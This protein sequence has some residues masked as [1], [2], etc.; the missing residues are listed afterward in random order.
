M[1]GRKDR[2]FLEK[3]FQKLTLNFTWWVNQKDKD[4]R[5]IFQGGFLGL[6]NIGI[7]N[8][9]KPLPMG[10]IPEQSDGTGWMGMYC[11]NLL[12]IALELAIEDAVYEDMAVKFLEHFIY[13]ADAIN[14]I[15]GRVDGL[16]DEESGFYRGFLRMPDGTR[17]KL[18]YDSIAGII[19]L[20]AVAVN[21]PVKKGAFPV[22]RKSFQWLV[23]N[24]PELIQCVIDTGKLEL[25]GKLLISLA[26][27]EKVR[28]MLNTLLDESK[29]LGKFGVRSVSQQLAKN[30]LVLRLGNEE[31]S[32]DYEPAESTSPLFGGNSNWRGPVWFPLNFLIIE[33]LQKYHYYLGDDFKIQCPTNSNRN[34]SLWDVS[35]DITGRLINIFL[36]DENGRRPLYGGIEKFQTDPHWKDYILFHEYFHGDNGAGLGASAQ[37]GW[38]ALVA[39]LI[40]QHGEYVINNKSPLPF[41]QWRAGQA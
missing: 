1:Y 40:Q 21:E 8:R 41:E 39:K 2:A 18:D 15:G 23:D 13:I 7:F 29:L 28:C 17:I 36:K 4:E 6:D 3:I 35:S 14:N 16:W 31:S 10:A 24:R 26:S 12:Q 37:T 19:P 27:P 9:S 5:N 32:L 22:Y 25:E 38:T 33:T 30:P 11:L 34:L 20:F